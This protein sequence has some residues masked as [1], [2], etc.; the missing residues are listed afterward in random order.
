MFHQ[1]FLNLLCGFISIKSTQKNFIHFGHVD[2]RSWETTSKI[3]N[4][5]LLDLFA[6]SN[7]NPHGSVKYIPVHDRDS[8]LHE[9]LEWKFDSPLEE[10][11]AVMNNQILQKKRNWSMSV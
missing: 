3:N 8:L 9:S 7:D 6:I 2:G 4:T 1:F 5:N 10:I 11:N